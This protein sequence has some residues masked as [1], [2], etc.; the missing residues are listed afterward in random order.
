MFFITIKKG[1][2]ISKQYHMLFMNICICSKCIKTWEKAAYQFLA[3][4]CFQEVREKWVWGK[5]TPVYL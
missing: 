5:E 4:N 2:G 1:K 3:S